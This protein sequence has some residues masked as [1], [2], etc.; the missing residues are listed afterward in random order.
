M[1]EFTEASRRNMLKSLAA[2]RWDQVTGPMAFVTLTY[3]REWPRDGGTVKA[4]LRAFR[5][6]WERRYGPV[7]AFWGMEFQQRGAPHFHLYAEMPRADRGE[8]QR[9][10]SEAWFELAGYGDSRHLAG[11]VVIKWDRLM[12][13]SVLPG[14]AP[15]GER[16]VTRDSPGNIA[17]Y[18]AKHQ[19]K[20][21]QKECPA[22]FGNPGRW[23]GFW[24]LKPVWHDREVGEDAYRRLLDRIGDEQEHQLGRRVEAS[25]RK[26]GLD[27]TWVVVPDG[28]SKGVAWLREVEAGLG[29]EESPPT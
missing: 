14:G 19:G 22:D 1:R 7:N 13:W 25:K 9:Y 17:K 2:V 29:A 21:G 23:W 24:G 16:R 20:E 5:K 8:V 26:D 10:L 6:R 15:E 12:G 27:G 18:M 3:G 4:Q 11:G 28:L